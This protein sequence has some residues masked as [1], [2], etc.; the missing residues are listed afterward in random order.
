MLRID[1][2][3]AL[4]ALGVALILLAISAAACGGS[5]A[6]TMPT[7]HS[8]PPSI[9]PPSDQGPVTPVAPAPNTPPIIKALYASSTRVEAD[10]RISLAADVQ[11]EDTPIDQLTYEWTSDKG[12]GTFI[13]TG[14]QVK[15]QAPHLE[16]TPDTYILTLTVIERYSADG[17]TRE[18]RISSSVSVHYNDSYREIRDMSLTFLGDFST[19]SVPPETCVRNFSDACPGKTEEL[20]DIRANRRDFVIQSGTFSVSSITLDEGSTNATA[21]LPCQFVSIRKSTGL[22]E[23]AAGKCVITG[24]YDGEKSRWL[25]CDSLFHPSSSAPVLRGLAP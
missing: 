24:T 11:D 12:T 18:N 8:V 22:P 6:P 21:T 3:S 13:G 5:G 25:L 16:K 15:W 17:E 20:S 23:T 9:E 19:Y 7:P 14:R 4:G 2:S 10:A 1:R